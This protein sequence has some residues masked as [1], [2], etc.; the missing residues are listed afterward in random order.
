MERRTTFP[1]DRNRLIDTHAHI[2]NEYYGEDR[3]RLLR[4]LKGQMQLLLLVGIDHKTNREAI[5]L[6]SQYDFIRAAVGR[7]PH[8]AETLSDPE[9]DR[10]RTLLKTN[11]V[12][13]LGEIGLD[14]FRLNRPKEAQL[15]LCLQLL[16]L[17]AETE[18]PVVLH[19]RSSKADAN[20]AFR[21]IFELLDQV[22]TDNLTGIFHCFSGDCENL[23]GI[24]ERGFYASYAGNL[25]YPGNQKLQ[26][27]AKLNP[28]DKLLVETDSPYLSPQPVRN[29]QNRPDYLQYTLKELAEL[30]NIT[31]IQLQKQITE[32][33]RRIF[34]INS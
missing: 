6:A 13:A 23:R 20:D 30:Q 27:A 22:G 26:A 34:Q 16:E 29:K 21:D 5:H 28:P 17:A 31:A 9:I 3:D 19:V 25:T 24:I 15:K 10:L 32:N 4:E 18:K 7:H 8:Y 2:F 12:V 11:A 14:Y 1:P 33:S